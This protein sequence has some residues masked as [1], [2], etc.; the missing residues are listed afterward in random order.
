MEKN[1]GYAQASSSLSTPFVYTDYNLRVTYRW[2]TGKSCNRGTQC[3]FD[4]PNSDHLTFTPL[5]QEAQCSVCYSGGFGKHQVFQ[6]HWT[7]GRRYSDCIYTCGREMDAAMKMDSSAGRFSNSWLSARAVDA[8]DN[9]TTKPHPTK[10]LYFLQFPGGKNV[11]WSTPVMQQIQALFCTDYKV[12]MRYPCRYTTDLYHDDSL[13]LTQRMKPVA[14]VCR[15]RYR[16][17]R[18]ERGTDDS[19]DLHTHY[20]LCRW[21]FWKSMYIFPTV[22]NSMAVHVLNQ[23][24]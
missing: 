17:N 23:D 21:T 18:P 5:T 12:E 7:L 11:F 4:K 2:D 24:I 6:T 22:E 3:G 20:R 14:T 16:R 15:R 9:K 8:S 10:V 1:T 13:L 19:S